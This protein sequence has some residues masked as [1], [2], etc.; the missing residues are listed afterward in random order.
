MK[1]RWFGHSCFYMISDSGI[2]ILTD[3]FA[4]QV[5]YKIPDV[6]VDIVTVSHNHYDHNN[7]KVVKGQFEFFNS[8]GLHENKGIKIKGISSFHDE[9]KGA[10]RGINIIFVMDIDGLRVCHLGDLGHIVDEQILSEIGQVDVLMIP[11]G[12][13]FT[14]YVQEAKEVVKLIK[15]K[16]TIPMHY[17]TPDLSFEL[18]NVQEFTKLFEPARV[19]KLQDLELEIKKVQDYEG[20]IILMKYKQDY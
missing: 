7:I 18:A 5:G 6:E 2:K 4:Q 17:K 12:E 15:P 20:N 9:V 3:P 1:I 11:V 16:I 10:K 19:K 13:I 8:T 14:L